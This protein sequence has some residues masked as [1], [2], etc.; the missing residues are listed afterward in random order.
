M[1]RKGSVTYI[2]TVLIIMLLSLP[3]TSCSEN[4]EKTEAGVY[5]T[6]N[7]KDT[8]EES[9]ES[10]SPAITTA[11]E[12]T[13]QGDSQ[14]SL[15][16]TP[17][18]IYFS[19]D[20]A[21]KMLVK[22]VHL[23]SVSAEHLVLALKDAGVLENGVEANSMEVTEKDGRT[24]IDLD[25][26]QVF[27]EKLNRMG[28]SGEY[29]YMGSIVNTF[30]QVFEA[31][32][33]RIT[34]DGAAPESGHAIYEGY[35]TFFKPNPGKLEGKYIFTDSREVIKPYVLLNDDGSFIFQY[36]SLMSSIP[37]GTYEEKG[38]QIIMKRQGTGT[39]Y[40]FDIQGENLIYN[41]EGSDN[42]QLMERAVFVPGY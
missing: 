3:L 24:L 19:D 10:D 1:K 15:S 40:V 36:S 26:N 13:G 2:S 38:N 28:T 5:A 14:P 4:R 22:E 8:E 42:T 23:P 31:Q 18:G 7:G 37:M 6:E 29:F 20:T 21:E 27:L 32:A 33:I 9:K 16:R 35:L 39:E 17:V 30:L 12:T 25:F 34:V 11:T 41:G